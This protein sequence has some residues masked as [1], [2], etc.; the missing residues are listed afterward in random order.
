MFIAA[1]FT[2]AK[3][4]KQPQ[5]SSECEWI[6]KMCYIQKGIYSAIE[7]NRILPLATTWMDLE[8]IILSEIVRERQIP[9]DLCVDSK[10]E[11]NRTKSQAQYIQRRIGCCQIRGRQGWVKGMKSVKRYKLPVIK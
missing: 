7:K 11:Q 8:G 6:V 3:I 9:Y 2:I 1:L 4:W 5:C 10:T